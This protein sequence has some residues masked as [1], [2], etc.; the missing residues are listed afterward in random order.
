MGLRESSKARKHSLEFSLLDEGGLGD[1]GGL[2]S[3]GN[4]GGGQ[5]AGVLDGLLRSLLVLVE[6]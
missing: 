5:V 1:D 2:G 4:L 3:V 6:G